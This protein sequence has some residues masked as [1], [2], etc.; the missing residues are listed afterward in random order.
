MKF[1]K[2]VALLVAAALS[3][4]CLVGCGSSSSAGGSKSGDKTL[5]ILTH[6]TDM[7]ET[8]KKY[9]EEFEKDHV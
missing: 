5:T 7:D 3:T 2:N 4:S 1:S 6:R 9:S 8:F